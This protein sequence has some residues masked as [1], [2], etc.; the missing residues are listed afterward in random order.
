MQKEES[1][2]GKRKRR[3]RGRAKKK[4]EMG[5]IRGGDSFH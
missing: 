3:R 4:W 5:V 2:A 1:K